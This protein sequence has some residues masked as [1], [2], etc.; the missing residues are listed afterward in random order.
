MAN[1]TNFS[2]DEL[3]QILSSYDL[4]NYK[5]STPFTSGTVQTNIKVK[6]TK[7]QFVFRYYENRS[8]QSALFETN[9]LAYLK[10]HD[11]PC[12]KPF[13]NQYGEFVGI[14]KQKPY[15]LFEYMEGEHITNPSENQK[16]QLIKL[17]AELHNISKNYI[18]LY[19]EDRLNYSV[20]TCRKL[21]EQQAKQLCTNNAKEKL[22]W[23]EKE[24]ESLVLPE[25][26]PKGICHSDFHFSNILYKDGTCKAL[27]DFDDANYTYLLFDLIVLIEYGA[28][29]HDVD[30]YLNVKEAKKIISEYMKYR[31]LSDMEK[32]HLFDIYKL[33]ILIDCV[34][35][36]DRGEVEN[37]YERRK[38][39][40]LNHIGRM[41][42]F[43]NLFR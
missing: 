39:E 15:V 43:E 6:T 41:K 26:L 18:P 35:Y 32:K 9:F 16:T 10:D 14:Y 36:F 29:Q 11:F 13:L 12:P 24:L 4:G 2:E 23:L 22:R 25:S 30:E 21:A 5:D 8:V 27:I 31:P 20:V 17:A 42:F 33:S 1:K 3:K 38:I 40:Y 34:R 7:G 28:W 37:F 19:K